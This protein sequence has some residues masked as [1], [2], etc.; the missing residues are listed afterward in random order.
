MRNT[1]HRFEHYEHQVERDEFGAIISEDWVL[2]GRFIGIFGVLTARELDEFVGGG[3]N[4]EASVRAPHSLT[5][6]EDDQV[7]V[8]SP[9]Q[10]RWT[11]GS[12]RWNRDHARLL[13]SKVQ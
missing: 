12:I 7:E 2:T 8:L 11:V 13:V 6:T 1:P 10:G 4:V 9:A 5:V 3:V